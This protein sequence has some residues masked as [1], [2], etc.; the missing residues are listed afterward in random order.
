MAN[1]YANKV[2]VNDTTLIDLTSDT[3][4]A[5]DVAQGVTFHLPSG[6]PATGTASGGTAAISVVDTQD[7]HGGTIRAI[8]AL[9]ISDTTAVASD[10]ASG[11]YFY[12]AG[13][14]KTQGTASGGGGATQH[15]IHFEFSDNTDTDIDVYYDDSYISTMITA[16]T[17]ATYGAKTVTLAQLDGVTWYEPAAI[18]LNT[19]LIDFTA[20]KNNYTINSSGVEESYPGASVSDYTLIDPSMT[21]EYKGY[22]WFYLGFYT[23]AKAPISTLYIDQDKDSAS[24]EI[25]T[26]T[27]NPAKI[28]ANAAYVRIDSLANPTASNLSLIRT[29]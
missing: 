27:L 13:G 7:I 2:V 20:V 19:Q 28:P 29:A 15:V 23:S 3:V 12:T 4:T 18:P 26:G 25:A 21:F 5:A 11:K 6:A 22:Q 16:Y 9:N 10:V 8:T 17:P 14:T 1:E 24:G